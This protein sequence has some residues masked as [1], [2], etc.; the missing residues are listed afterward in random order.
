MEE[1]RRREWCDPENRARVRSRSLTMAL[2]DRLH[3]NSYSPSI[4]IMA[5]SCIV[6]ELLV[7]NREIIIPHLYLVPRMGDPVGI[8]RRCLIFIKLERSGYRVV[9]KT[10][11]IC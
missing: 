11:T 2:L 9:K 7:K 10:M 8:S 3:T 6:T 1:K 5:L 4:V